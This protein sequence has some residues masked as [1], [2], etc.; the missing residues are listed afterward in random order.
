MGVRDPF[1]KLQYNDAGILVIF[2]S[3][4]ACTLGGCLPKGGKG[5][6]ENNLTRFIH[7][8]PD[9]TPSIQ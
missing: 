7:P 3:L 9:S 6:W 5:A 1:H 8:R 4:G 2:G